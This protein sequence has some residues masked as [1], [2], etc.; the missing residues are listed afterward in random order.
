MKGKEFLSKAV[1]WE[2]PDIEKVRKN[3]H[4]SENIEIIGD[5]TTR[6]VKVN[7]WSVFAPL[8]VSFA[9]VIAAVV[10]M[11]P[12]SNKNRP[13]LEAPLAVVDSTNSPTTRFGNGTMINDQAEPIISFETTVTLHPPEF[14]SITSHRTGYSTYEDDLQNAGVTTAPNVWD[15]TAPETRLTSRGGMTIVTSPT[16]RFTAA[17]TA[18]VTTAPTAKVTTAPTARVT[19]APTVRVTT[20]PTTGVVTGPWTGV[21]TTGFDRWPVAETT[22]TAK[23]AGAGTESY[24]P[25]QSVLDAVQIS[26]VA[27]VRSGDKVI[28][29]LENW[30]HGYGVWDGHQ[31]SASGQPIGAVYFAEFSDIPTIT[32]NPND[33][34]IEFDLTAGTTADIP[35]C[36]VY[37]KNLN[38][39]LGTFDN[40]GQGEKFNDIFK[41]TRV[42]AG[43]FYLLF[44]TWLH[45]SETES[46]SRYNY[47]VKLIVE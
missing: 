42:G 29:P 17:P 10:I 15:A 30:N 2:K 41:S 22:T 16:A 27:R 5:Q 25:P 43:E 38:E 46:G 36:R 23:Y 11:N 45:Y 1:T 31:Y 12:L 19:T 47:F 8:A 33:F 7:S 20:A 9:I 24:R 3:C 21:E 37:D 6:I 44:S 14:Y 35:Y 34:R 28:S 18:R 32:Y 40:V 13:E 4:E 26:S 39:I